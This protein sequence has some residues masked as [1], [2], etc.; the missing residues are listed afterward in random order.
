[1]TKLENPRH[2]KVWLNKYCPTAKYLY[3]SFC[4]EYNDNDYD[5]TCEFYVLLNENQEEVPCI[6]PIEAKENF[7]DMYSLFGLSGYEGTEYQNPIYINLET[8]E[9]TDEI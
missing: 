1:M 8:M 4:N 9:I 3:Y 2:L 6:N 7:P 5:I